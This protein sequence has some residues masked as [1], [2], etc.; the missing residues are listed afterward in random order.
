MAK[1]KLSSLEDER[2]RLRRQ[3]RALYISALRVEDPQDST[4]S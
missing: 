3:E 4:K 2:A 1:K